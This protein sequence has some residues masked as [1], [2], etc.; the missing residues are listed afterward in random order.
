MLQGHERG[1][2][3]ALHRD[4]RVAVPE[5]RM[6]LDHAAD[7]SVHLPAILRDL[8]DLGPVVLC[9]GEIVP[10]HL[11]HARLKQGLELLVD[12]ALQEPRETELVDVEGRGVG[13]IEDERVPEAVVRR[14]TERDLPLERREEHL[15]ERPAVVEVVEHLAPRAALQIR[16]RQR[17]ERSVHADA[18]TLRWSAPRPPPGWTRADEWILTG[19][20]REDGVEGVE[21]EV[22]IAARGLAHVAALGSRGAAEADSGAAAGRW[23]PFQIAKIAG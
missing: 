1:P 4:G 14:T 18:G 12:G 15:R 6:R 13:V 23:R 2:Q 16:H 17:S 11:V 8:A 22:G 3:R 5:I 10:R 19:W 9:R 20:R 21:I 7:R